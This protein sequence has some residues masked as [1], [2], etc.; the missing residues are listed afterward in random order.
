LDLSEENFLHPSAFSRFRKKSQKGC[1]ATALVLSQSP[2]IADAVTETLQQTIKTWF[3][4]TFC[5]FSQKALGLKD[6]CNDRNQQNKGNFPQK[7][8][9]I[10]NKQHYPSRRLDI[11]RTNEGTT[12]TSL[13]S[14]ATSPLVSCSTSDS[15]VYM[16]AASPLAFAGVICLS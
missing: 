15:C 7:D 16:A 12:L 2:K 8:E 6:T 3:A 1:R 10:T 5:G 4:V 14:Y 9:G 13:L 11:S